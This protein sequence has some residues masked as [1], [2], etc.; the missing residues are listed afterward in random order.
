MAALEIVKRSDHNGVGIG[1]N[2]EG[3]CVPANVRTG[4]RPEGKQNSAVRIAYVAGYPA[5]GLCASCARLWE[6][7][8]EEAA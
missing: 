7:T 3:G 6:R 2:C 4:R 1:L 5:A 8:W